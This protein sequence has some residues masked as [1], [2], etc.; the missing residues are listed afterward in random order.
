MN[1]YWI[2]KPGF[3]LTFIISPPFL[4]L[5]FVF[6]FQD[7]IV[8]WQENYSFYTW[9]LVI[10]FVDVAHVYGTLYKTYFNR[11]GSEY[12]RKEL[13]YVPL[14]CFIIGFFLYSLGFQVFWSVMA[15]VAVYHFIRQ[16]YGFM[17]L[18]SKQ[19]ANVVKWIDNAAIYNAT[20][21]PMLFWF[22]S[23]ERNFSWFVENEF[24][25]FPN[26]VVVGVITII[27]FLIVTLYI[28]YVGYRFLS[29]GSFNLPKTMLVL[30]TYL[31]WYFGIVHFIM[32]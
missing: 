18:Y 20:I 5:G 9:L 28:F 10:V 24:L 8:Y 1:K 3:D 30:G 31:S 23:P 4:V 21:Y 26:T 12:Y 32:I 15:Y 14:A 25:G 19:E 11:H 17:R 16:Q 7:N 13:L 22:F 29:N 27:Y 2:Y 6:L